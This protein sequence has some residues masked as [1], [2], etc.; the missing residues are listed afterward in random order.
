MRTN[1]RNTHTRLVKKA[2]AFLLATVSCF[3]L[4]AMPKSELGGGLF[5]NVSITA[6][7]AENDFVK[8]VN[9]CWVGGTGNQ[10]MP[11]FELQPG[12]WY[13]SNNGSYVLVFQHDGNLVI[14]SSFVGPLR[15]EQRDSH[16]E[17]AVWS[18]RSNKR[19]GKHCVMQRDGN[20]VIYKDDCKTPVWSSN[21]TNRNEPTFLEL[22]NSGELRIVTHAIESKDKNR[23][24]LFS[25][26]WGYGVLH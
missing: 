14:Y 10:S 3:S 22:T 1:P 17:K 12:K 25:S 9:D 20:L 26:N 4:I 18:S 19:G 24:Q 6:N 11:S 7:A 23:R 13:V 21:T 15:D 8:S 16:L 2:S 5:K